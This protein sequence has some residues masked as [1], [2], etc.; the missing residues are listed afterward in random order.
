MESARG[1]KKITGKISYTVTQ[2]HFITK[3]IN[4]DKPN[5]SS[6]NIYTD[7]RREAAVEET[8]EEEKLAS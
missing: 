3:D 4:K 6:I 5:P 2:L 1:Q 8:A 7:G